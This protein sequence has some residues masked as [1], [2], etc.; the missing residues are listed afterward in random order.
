M[1][2]VEVGQIYVAAD[3]GKY[4][5]IVTDVD[6]FASC[7]DVVTIPFTASGWGENGNR[8][9]AFKLARVRYCLYSKSNMVP[10]W[11]KQHFLD[12]W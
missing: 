7:G 9:D 11:F 4:G 6:A 8:I 2:G 5:H 3:G 12:I 1:Y 10:L